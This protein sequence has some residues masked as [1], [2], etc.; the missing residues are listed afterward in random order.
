MTSMQVERSVSGSSRF[1]NALRNSW[2][3]RTIAAV[4]VAPFAYVLYQEFQAG[5][6]GLPQIVAIL[7][8]ASIILTMIVR[9]P[10]VRIT[11]N[12]FFWLL[13]FVATYGG[14]FVVALYQPGRALAPASVVNTIDVI[15]LIVSLW[16]RLSLGRNIGVV[17]AERQIVTTGAY[18]YVRHPIY[19]G[20]FLSLIALQLSG[21][22]WR[23]LLLD[24]ISAGLWIVKT[25]VEERFLS[26]NQQYA[27]YMKKVPWRWFP[28]IA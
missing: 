25:F 2:I 14:L 15:S 19:T 22:S 1:I 13:A 27:E 10:P 11:T 18:R 28:W 21:F 8:F 3:D 12:P 24:G 17:P 26:K 9:R 6:L 5:K 7:Q 20:I 4:A 23:N 16:A